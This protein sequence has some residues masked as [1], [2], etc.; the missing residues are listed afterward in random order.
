MQNKLT[1]PQERAAWKR[2]QALADGALP[3]LRELLTD[4]ADAR[5]ASL[6]LEA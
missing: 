1:P 6:Q 4:D 3:H 5:H 2:L